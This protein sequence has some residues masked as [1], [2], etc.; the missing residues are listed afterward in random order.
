MI[1]LLTILFLISFISCSPK[2]YVYQG[3][4]LTKRQF[5]K[6]IDKVTTD[7][8]NNNPRFVELWNNVEVVYDT[9]QK[10]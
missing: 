8:I 4:K 2:I 1:R 6:R 5:H 7:F 9:I 10:K 3:E